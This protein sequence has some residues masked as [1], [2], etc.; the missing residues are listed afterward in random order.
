MKKTT[1][2]A[3]FILGLNISIIADEI[4]VRNIY[5]AEITFSDASISTN[6]DCNSKL[7]KYLSLLDAKKKEFREA[8]C[9][10]DKGPFNSNTLLLSELPY[11]LQ[12]EDFIYEINRDIKKNIILTYENISTKSLKVDL[13]NYFIKGLPSNALLVKKSIAKNN[14]ITSDLFKI[15]YLEFEIKIKKDG[16][17]L[18]AFN[19]GFN[20]LD[21]TRTYLETITVPNLHYFNNKKL[22]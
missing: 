21:V 7:S 18:D 13:S 5:T 15:N 16:Y 11:N 1:F 10:T 17:L 22:Y 4:K 20:G 3:L 8:W 14:P 9:N 12:Y 19:R 2:I 6:I